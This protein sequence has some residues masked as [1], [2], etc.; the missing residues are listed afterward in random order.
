MPQIEID[1]STKS[2]DKA[3]IIKEFVIMQSDRHWRTFALID[4]G[5]NAVI[6]NMAYRARIP[7]SGLLMISKSTFHE[8]IE[9]SAEPGV[10]TMS[11][12]RAFPT[13]VNALFRVN[14]TEPRM[15]IAELTK[16]ICDARMHDYTFVDDEVYGVAGC[17][18]WHICLVGELEEAGKV[19][20]GAAE[21]FVRF[22]KKRSDELRGADPDDQIAWPS[23]PGIFNTA[24][25]TFSR[26]KVEALEEKA[27]GK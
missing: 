10:F 20:P 26:S 12:S 23:I 18:F 4:G 1:D 5:F 25:L 7:E 17:R 3:K 8:P 13:R 24:R 2:A 21:A 11:N 9:R 16:L 14:P 19:S 6:Y 22:I 15:T 27:E